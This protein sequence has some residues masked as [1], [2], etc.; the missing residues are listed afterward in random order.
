MLANQTLCQMLDIPIPPTALTGADSRTVLEQCRDLFP[1]PESFVS[2][3]ESILEE[4]RLVRNEELTLNDGRVFARDFIPIVTQNYRAHLWQYRDVTERKTA[5]AQILN[6]KIEAE[7]A[8]AA[9]SS[10]LAM[11]SHELRTPLNAILG[12]TELVARHEAS[13]SEQ[14]EFL[15]H[16]PDELR[17]PPAS[18]RRRPR[19]FQDRSEPHGSRADRRSILRE[20]ADE[21]AES[22]ERPRDGRRTSSS[23]STST[24]ICLRRSSEIPKRVRQVLLNLV[25]NAVKFTEK[26]YVQ[27]DGRG[28]GLEARVDRVDIGFVV[29]DTG[30]GIPKDKQKNL[31]SKF[32]Q[33]E[34]S[35]TQ[36]ASA[37]A[38]SGSISRS[39]HRRAHERT[40]RFHERARTREARFA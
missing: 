3:V 39:S 29:T 18:H 6:A 34:S 37:E 26:G 32:Y 11:M 10:F 30:I 9:K 17:E 22:V 38:A 33:A 19:S 31:F 1:E 25:G 21:V 15:E 28:R 35:T 16:D 24:R 27:L 5:E 13:T 20:L 23:S 8:N 4:H 14:R 36:E 7:E 2:R 40:H 12:M